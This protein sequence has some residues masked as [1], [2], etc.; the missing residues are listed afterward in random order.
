MHPRMP[1]KKAKET[2]MET[3]FRLQFRGKT[4]DLPAPLARTFSNESGGFTWFLSISRQACVRPAK[5]GS[6]GRPFGP[7]RSAELRDEVLG[8]P[9][10]SGVQARARSASNI[11]RHRGQASSA[12]APSQLL[13]RESSGSQECRA[14]ARHAH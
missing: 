14:R 1:I 2:K 4:C 11:L 12:L 8:C 3:D 10:R 7:I 9:S 6:N 13:R 5:F